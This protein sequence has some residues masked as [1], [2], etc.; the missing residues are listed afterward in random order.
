MKWMTQLRNLMSTLPNLVLAV[1]V[2]ITEHAISDATVLDFRRF[3]ILSV[4]IE[5]SDFS[6]KERRPLPHINIIV[7]LDCDLVA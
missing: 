2:E 4:R 5:K 1:S 6:I 3:P 7:Y